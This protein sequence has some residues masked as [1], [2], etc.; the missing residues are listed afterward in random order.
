MLEERANETKFH[1]QINQSSKQLKRTV[2]DLDE[3]AKRRIEMQQQ[4]IE[5]NNTKQPI[6]NPTQIS[7]KSD[8]VVYDRFELDFK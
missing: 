2:M 7:S 5:Y 3:D 4:I 1:P 6:M 8:K